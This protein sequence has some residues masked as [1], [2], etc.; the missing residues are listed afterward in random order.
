[1]EMN[2]NAISPRGIDPET[3]PRQRQQTIIMIPPPASASP[4]FTAG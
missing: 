4:A 3:L 2:P 1:M